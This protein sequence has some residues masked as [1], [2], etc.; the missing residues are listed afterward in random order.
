MGFFQ[1][2]KFWACHEK[3]VCMKIKPWIHHQW[4]SSHQTLQHWIGG[5]GIMKFVKNTPWWS[6]F[7]WN[8]RLFYGHFGFVSIYFWDTLGRNSYEKHRILTCAFFPDF[9]FFPTLFFSRARRKF[10]KHKL[11]NRKFDRVPAIE[12]FLQSLTRGRK[13]ATGKKRKFRQSPR[14]HP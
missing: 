7:P 2:D 14:S 11:K 10:F 13:R 6:I 12:Q 1:T 9:F 3:L 4:I 5:K 8:I